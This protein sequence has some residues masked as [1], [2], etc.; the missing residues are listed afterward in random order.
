MT[1]DQNNVINK[2]IKWGKKLDKTLKYDASASQAELYVHLRLVS[3]YYL[4]LSR[5]H[6]TY[7]IKVKV[8]HIN[9]IICKQLHS[10]PIQN[11]TAPL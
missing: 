6:R 4:H 11:W 3:R 9:I 10:F 2:A 8:L 1:L 5:T 7:D